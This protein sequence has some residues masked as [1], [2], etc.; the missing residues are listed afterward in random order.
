MSQ[1][2]PFQVT[3]AV[4]QLI[5]RERHGELINTSLV[6]GVINCYVELG[7]NSN[8]STNNLIYENSF[9]NLF[10]N[11]TE[12]F[13]L[14]ES[15]NLLSTNTISEYM[16]KVEER[17]Q[18]ETKRVQIYLHPSTH[19][20]LQKACEKIL[21]GKYINEFNCE[22][23]IFLV[24]WRTTDLTRMYQLLSKIPNGLIDLKIIFENFV[25]QDGLSILDKCAD[26]A[27]NVRFWGYN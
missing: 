17:L 20:R 2:F 25:L 9:E 26:A 27:I 12:H 21:I 19:D 11:E 8:L 6:S 7:L 24:S 22:F 13:Y 23:I 16:K 18:E 14:Q 4:L 3:A 15:L 10:I 1:N 5:E